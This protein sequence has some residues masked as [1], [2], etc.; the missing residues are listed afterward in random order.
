[1]ATQRASRRRA[2]AR[3]AATRGVCRQYAGA[4]CRG[5]SRHD[6]AP[7]LDEIPPRAPPD[8]APAASSAI[9]VE[10]HDDVVAHVE[11]RRNEIAVHEPG[12]VERAAPPGRGHGGARASRRRPPTPTASSS[13][14]AAD[15]RA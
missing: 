2:R 13:G 8:E 11:V 7:E 5:Q 4:V 9:V 14:R 10:E 1:V 12:A 15:V 6:E 3:Q